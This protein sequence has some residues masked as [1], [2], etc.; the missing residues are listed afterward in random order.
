LLGEAITA[1]AL[2]SGIC[3]FLGFRKLRPFTPALFPFLY[4]FMVF[5]EAPISGTSTNPARSLGPALISGEW[6]G[7]WIYWVGP[8]I[9]TF[10]ATLACSYFEKRVEVA[11]LYYF[12]NDRDG[13]F[14]RGSR[15]H[16]A[17]VWLP[18]PQSHLNLP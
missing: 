14:R 10:V 9:G 12:D 3:V 5:V 13:L 6:Q 7:W 2:I 18:Q 16:L 4:A 15:A 8:L 17:G 11:K 1:F